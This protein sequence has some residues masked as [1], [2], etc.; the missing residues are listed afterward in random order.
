LKSNR[1]VGLDP[2][3]KPKPKLNLGIVR[4]YYLHR[5]RTW[6]LTPFSLSWRLD[7]F[8]RRTDGESSETDFQNPITCTAQQDPK[9]LRYLKFSLILSHRR[10]NL[11]C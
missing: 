2:K 1:N 7:I 8:K 10:R 4:R 11:R 3:S 6:T 9:F 5:R